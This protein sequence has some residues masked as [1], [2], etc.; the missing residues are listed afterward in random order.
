ML[1]H[2]LITQIR[3]SLSGVTHSL[4]GAVIARGCIKVA[5]EKADLRITLCSKV[6]CI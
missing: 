6:S 5:H 4:G 3:V 1:I 2:A